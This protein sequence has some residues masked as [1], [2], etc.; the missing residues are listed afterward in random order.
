M[1]S[2]PD[3]RKLVNPNPD[4]EVA[5]QQQPAGESN[6]DHRGETDRER[7]RRI[8]IGAYY[9]A[10]HRGFEEG[11]ELDD[12]LQ[13]EQEYEKSTGNHRT[14]KTTPLVSSGERSDANTQV[15]E[16]ADVRRWA[17]RLNV[18]A[19]RLREAIRNVGNKLSDVRRFLSKSN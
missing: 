2:K 12:W 10:E 4:A 7:Q 13:A 17:P 11:G 9:N 19:T 8:A 3:I 15:I 14:A 5:G 18:S 1:N 16:P 6:L